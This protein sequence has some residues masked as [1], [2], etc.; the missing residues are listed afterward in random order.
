MY[1]WSSIGHQGELSGIPPTNRKVTANGIAIYR[2]ANGKRPRKVDEHRCAR[3]P[4][5]IGRYS[6]FFQPELL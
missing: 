2:F 1:D 5:T 4:E 6:L 3:C